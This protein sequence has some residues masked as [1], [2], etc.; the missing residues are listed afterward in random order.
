MIRHVGILG[1]GGISDTHARAAAAVPDLRVAAVCG[2]NASRVAALAARHDA[3]PFTDVQAFLRHRPMEIV[4]IGTPSGL[5]A[6][7]IEAAA[8][9]GL[10]VLCEKPLDVTT[11]RIDRMLEAVERAGITL[12]VFFQ[13]RST[14]D[15]MD[16]KDALVSGRLGR[17]ILA[18]AQVKWYRPPEYYAQSPWRGTWALDGGGALMNQGVHTV[19][20]LLWLLGDVRRVYARTLAALHAIDVE[21]TAVAVLEFANGAVATLEATTAAWPGY[22]RRVS[23]TGTLGTVVIEL[24]RV[25][26]WDVREPALEGAAGGAAVIAPTVPAAAAPAGAAASTH[27]VADASPH[28]RVFEDFV[29]ALDAG[30]PPRVDGREGRRSVALIEA[31]YASSRSGQPVDVTS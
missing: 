23:I 5:H 14:P 11:A 27:V 26:K 15:L 19:D 31:I 16:V 28:R 22:D 1:G 12:G 29:S 6:D 18:D 20:L 3:V 30:R 7:D 4:A 24:A 9:H 8:A 10:H 17:P 13:D 25:V 2:R 21:D